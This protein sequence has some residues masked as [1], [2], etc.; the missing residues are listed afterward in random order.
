MR[1]IGRRLVEA[2]EERREANLFC[3]NLAIAIQ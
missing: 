2:T 1:A 3:Q